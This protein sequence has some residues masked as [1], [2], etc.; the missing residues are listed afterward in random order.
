MLKVRVCL[1][2]QGFAS[3]GIQTS[4]CFVTEV[5][6]VSVYR[7]NL[8][9]NKMKK[10]TFAIL[11]LISILLTTGL[12]SAQT[13]VMPVDDETGLITYQE[14][15]EGEGDKESFFNSAVGWINSFYAN[16]VNVTKTRNPESG[17]I[18]GLHRFKLKNTDADGLK[19]DAGTVQYEFTLEFK[20]GRY[21]YTLTDFVL[22]QASRIPVEKWLNTTDPQ[23][24]SYLKQLDDF[25]K[26]WISSLKAGML[27]EVEKTDDEW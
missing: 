15:V 18:K 4:S 16:P 8:K 26:S 21:R 22:R 20:E 6:V 27:P 14:V 2:A 7:G 23:S 19:T 24:K 1:K 10:G 9:T 3:Q 5:F 25:A 13:N 11:L 17:L 12:L